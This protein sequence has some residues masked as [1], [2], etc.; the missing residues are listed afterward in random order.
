MILMSQKEIQE[1]QQKATNRFRNIKILAKD[2]YLHWYNNY[3]SYELIAE[4]YEITNQLAIELINMGREI[5]N[6]TYF[7]DDYAEERNQK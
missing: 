1:R 3:I 5:N 7:Y 2:F 4:H 6:G